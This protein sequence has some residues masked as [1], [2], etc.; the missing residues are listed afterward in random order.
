[1]QERV[2]YNAWNW[3]LKKRQKKKGLT[4]WQTKIFSIKKSWQQLMIKYWK[5]LTSLPIYITLINL[6]RN[7]DQTLA[8]CKKM[9]TVA[10]YES[11]IDYHV[12][13]KEITWHGPSWQILSLYPTFSK[14]KK[15]TYKILSS[16]R[17]LLLL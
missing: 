6:N 12:K 8:T 3:T 13:L 1:M 11:T 4:I 17:V 15:K 9:Y 14:L 2:I 16:V 5:W 7:L 10:V